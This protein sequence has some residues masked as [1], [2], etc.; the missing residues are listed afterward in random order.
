M[1]LKKFKIKNLLASF[2][3][4]LKRFPTAYFYA[5]IFFISSE[6]LILT[7]WNDN[8]DVKFWLLMI[9]YSLWAIIFAILIKIFSE[10]KGIKKYNFI[11]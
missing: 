2:L 8:I 4:S 6:Y 1:F 7:D 11:G 3:L 5:L 10:K 9:N